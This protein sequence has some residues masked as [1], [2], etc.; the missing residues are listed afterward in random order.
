MARKRYTT[1]QIIAQ[2]REAEVALAKG[3]SVATVV[4]QL[5]VAEQTDSRWRREDGGLHVAQAKRRKELEKENQRLRRVVADQA[6]GNT[7]L[8]DVASGNF[9]ARCT[10]ARRSA[11]CSPRWP[12]RSVGR[13]A[14]CGK[15]GARNALRPGRPRMRPP[16]WRASSPWRRAGRR[17][18]A[19]PPR[20]RR[21]WLADGTTTRRRA[22]RPNHV[23]SDDFVQDRTHDGRPLRLLCVVAAST[24][25]CLAIVVAR[26][27][28]AD[29]VLACLTQRFVAR[30][31]P[32]SL[33]SDNGPACTAHAVRSWLPRVGV[34]T[35][36]IQPGSPWENG[37]VASFNGNLRDACLNRE[38]FTTLAEAQVLIARW[39]REYNEQRPHSALG[40][41][42]PAPPTIEARPAARLPEL[43]PL[44]ALTGNVVQ[45]WG[46][47]QFPTGL[48]F[49]N[50]GHWSRRLGTPQGR[51]QTCL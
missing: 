51:P 2:R 32:T 4:R 10:G 7:I 28:R 42:P 8:K 50:R 12:S 13:V 40:S 9:S 17:V 43:L 48:R 3:D 29:D 33:R 5:G 15:R 22:T 36:F 35:L 14:S 19:K 27:L 49:A 45:S 20:R 24:R 23:W 18:P 31:P 39:R 26:R 34:T 1:E 41:R 47:G 25:A 21:W 6:L 44:R 11:P 16:W 38:S 37:S 46:A 30:G